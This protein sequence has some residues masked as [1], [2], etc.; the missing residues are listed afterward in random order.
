MPLIWY[1]VSTINSILINLVELCVLFLLYCL[2]G[3][4]EPTTPG[5]LMTQQQGLKIMEELVQR[6][7]VVYV[8][9]LFLVGKHRKKVSLIQHIAEYLRFVLAQPISD[10]AVYTD[11]FFLHYS[12]TTLL[13]KQEYSQMIYLLVFCVLM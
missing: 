11:N 10:G 8:L 2:A 9:G 6:V 12:R 7:E 1:W 4:S 13:N 3:V 5:G